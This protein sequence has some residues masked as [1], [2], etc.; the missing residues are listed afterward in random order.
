MSESLQQARPH[1]RHTPRGC[2]PG[3]PIRVIGTEGLTRA[4]DA[5]R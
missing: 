1:G 5:G 2:V 4:T 3:L